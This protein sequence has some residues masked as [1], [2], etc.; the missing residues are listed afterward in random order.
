MRSPGSPI[1]LAL[2]LTL[3]LSAGAEL[4][5]PQR[6][7]ADAAPAS[8]T[9]IG[10]VIDQRNA[11]PIKD[12]TVSLLQG[13]VVAA[14]SNTDAF[15]S[16][17]ITGV[18]AGVYDVSVRAR[19]YS[20]SSSLNVVVNSGSVVTVNAALVAATNASSIHT[21][22]T[23]T[24]TGGAL[25]SATAITQTVNVQN[26]AQ[27]GQIRIAN[28]LNTLPAINM[29]TSS[30][31]GDDVSINMRGFGS[32][33]T[34]ALLNGHP[35]GP[36]GVDAKDTF[37][38]ADTNLLALENVDV[39]YGSGAQGLFGS[40]TVA[41]A[42]NMQLIH[43]TVTPQYNLQQSIGGDGILSTGVSTTGTID[44]WGYAV[45]AGVSGLSGVLNGDIF[46]SA[47]PAL[48]QNGSVTP[49]FAC[50]N[51]SGNDVSACDRA[52]ET[53]PV[54]Q[55]SKLTSELADFRYAFAP[56]TS[57][58][59]S[60]YSTV[61]YGN[62][63]GNGDNDFLPYA[64]RLA[65]LQYSANHGGY[66]CVVGGG[67]GSPNG[68][69]VIT[70]PLT[71]TNACYTTQQ[72]AATSWGPD[73][74][75][76]GRNRSA[77][78]RDYD[79]HFVTKEGNN[80]ISVDGFD[81]NYYYEK[82]SSLSGGLDAN[83]FKLGTP[84]FTDYFDT[85][86]YVISDDL[87]TGDND[88]GFGYALLDQFQWGQQVVGV[89]TN[90]LTGE[91]ILGFAPHF[92][93]ATFR[94]NSFF[95]RDTH[96]F[97]DR[98]SGFLNAWVKR[99][100]VTA[101]TTF[102]PRITGQYRP[103][104]NDVLRLTYGHSDGPPAPLLGATGPLFEPNPGSSL[105]HV[106]CTP[107]S[108]VL[109]A[110]VGNPNITSESANDVE[111]GY[112]HRFADDSNIQVNAYAT[113]VQNQI[114]SANLPLTQVGINNI[115]FASGTLQKYLSYLIQQSCLP[116][117]AT[118]S[119]VYPFLAVPT[120][121]NAANELARGTDLNGRYRFMR[122]AYFDY[123]YSVESSQQMDIPSKILMNN[124]TLL[125]GGQQN[126]IPLHQGNLSL[127]VQPGQ[128]EFRLDNFYIGNNNPLDRPAYWYSNAFLSHPLQGGR[129]IVTLGGTNIFNQAVQTYGFIGS[130]TP[131]AV[132]QF[133]PPAADNGLAQNIAGI[134]SN[135][136]FGIQPAQLTFTV[137]V[138][139]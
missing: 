16:F 101:K 96:Q 70:N 73:G 71:A 90:S 104:S 135:E 106:T 67:T 53:Y 8:G 26:L 114:F 82:D 34:A 20:P 100:N 89:G 49:N 25:A 22:G 115:T 9:V 119:Q 105:T 81:N 108:N 28:Q 87:V 52:A 50:G 5:A 139:M 133:A 103:D 55:Q 92:P 44:R 19:G 63:T 109:G 94:E 64:T 128:F 39:T 99:P 36:L 124:F 66:N 57:L 30:S 46:Q 77:S 111:L 80:N 51:A 31:P 54:G 14:S 21:L 118:L 129:Y 91:A 43:P 62:S 130:G 113:S 17:R 11:L 107:D 121:Y 12:A 27:T 72:W 15:G 40:D 86:G 47:R 122:K 58:S 18:S 37:N 127:D 132:N 61:Q 74:G 4:F 120:Y 24:V 68:F 110:S 1:G 76:N 102:D 125:N 41:G 85:H 65:Q 48:L 13:A 136:E 83:G 2:A 126:G 98:F 88:F 117:G 23:V 59:I 29:A 75:G 95:V 38:Y 93:S 7:L 3:V 33:E 35:I 137:S 131:Q 116:A 138:K 6:A 134:A 78:M 97:G 45:E 79:A 32:S 84:D 123:G 60:G 112:G 10:T 42:V 56:N 69:T